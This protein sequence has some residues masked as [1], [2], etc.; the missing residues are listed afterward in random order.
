MPRTSIKGQVLA[1]LMAEFAECPEEMNVENHD[2]DEKSI[3]V[4][5]DHP[6]PPIGDIRMIVGE[7]TTTG[8][9]KKAR[10]TYL[11]KVQNVQL[12]G[13]VPKIA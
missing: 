1:D 12:T 4:D 3:A 5:N 2:M 11:R 6:R 7:T 8:S 10:K 9:S 13:F